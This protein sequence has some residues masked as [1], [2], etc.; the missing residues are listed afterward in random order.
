M[1]RLASIVFS[2]FGW[3]LMGITRKEK[4]RKM[5]LKCP[6][7]YLKN[8]ISTLMSIQKKKTPP[9]NQGNNM[10]GS[11]PSNYITKIR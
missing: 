7:D 1:Q 9:N 3:Y 4:K 5:H 10:L 8:K 2:F 11:M 6:L